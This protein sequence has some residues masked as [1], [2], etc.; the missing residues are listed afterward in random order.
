MP[1]ASVD[2]DALVD[3]MFGTLR[4]GHGGWLVTANLDHLHRY[5]RDADLRSLYADAD[6][7]VADGMP[8]VWA[9]RVQG[10]PLPQRVAGSALIYRFA[11]RAAREGCS[12]Y[13]L[14]GE[15][16]AA[17]EAGRVLCARFPGLRIVGAS[18]PMLQNPP[19]AADLA[20]VR[21][22]LAGVQPDLLLVGLGS[23]KQERLIQLLRAD[24]PRTWLVGV[25]ISFSFVSGRVARAPEWMRQ[26]GL[27]WVHRLVQ[28]PGRLARRYLVNDVP[29]AFELLARS[30]AT[31]LRR[32]S[33]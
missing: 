28:E 1:L 31:R 10:S 17:V 11:E 23:P 25:G 32:P 9:S 30:L 24:F 2:E 8:L 20:S 27:E 5:T 7:I 16:G 13:L 3:H 26:S 18:A 15:P 22:E 4:D 19:T 29:F 33:R 12:L 14:G 6:L 21:A